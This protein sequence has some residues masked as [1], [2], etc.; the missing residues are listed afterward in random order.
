[1]EIRVSALKWLPCINNKTY[2]LYLYSLTSL[3]IRYCWQ[4]ELITAIF[5]YLEV[6]RLFFLNF[7]THEKVFLPSWVSSQ[8][9]F[10]GLEWFLIISAITFV[11]LWATLAQRVLKVVALNIVSLFWALYYYVYYILLTSLIV[12]YGY[13]Y[14]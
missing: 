8:K 11:T 1:M 4:R 7:G 9:C 3:N 14:D 2:L 12:F 6:L 10:Q 13:L 5:K